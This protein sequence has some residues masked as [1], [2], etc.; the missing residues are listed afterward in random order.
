MEYK[1]AKAFYDEHQNRL[2][3]FFARSEVSL[4]QKSH[5]PYESLA[6]LLAAKEAIF[7]SADLPWMGADGFRKIRIIS[8]KN[9]ELCFRLSGNFKRSF[10]RRWAPVL[11]FMKS[12]DYVIAECRPRKSRNSL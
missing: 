8:R 1:K 2:K 10:S 4:I 7:K 12:K 11:S 3:D 5:K 6:L 9:Q